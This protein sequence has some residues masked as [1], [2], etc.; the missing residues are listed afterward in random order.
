MT[1]TFSLSEA[2]DAYLELKEIKKQLES[3]AKD[4]AIQMKN[5]QELVQKQQVLL[6]KQQEEIQELAFRLEEVEARN[7]K[8]A[9]GDE[10]G[11]QNDIQTHGLTWSRQFYK[12][13]EWGVQPAVE[14]LISKFI[15]K[16]FSKSIFDV[17]EIF[18]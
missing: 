11:S 13:D 2:R 5:L 18:T 1:K 10:A 7:E 3:Q 8:V 12:L 16:L 4:Q 9:G 6:E 17:I 15:T 14:A